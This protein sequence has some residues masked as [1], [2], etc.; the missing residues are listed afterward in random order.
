MNLTVCPL[1]TW[2][3]DGRHQVVT[4]PPAPQPP[5]MINHL[6]GLGKEN[7]GSIYKG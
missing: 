6:M 7:L 3:G 1:W 2:Q 5:L 4:N